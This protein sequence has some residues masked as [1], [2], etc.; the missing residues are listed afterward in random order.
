V[1]GLDTNAIL[2]LALDDDPAQCRRV[3]ALLG[4]ASEEMF[5]ISTI[6]LVEATWTLHRQ[7]KRTR[8]EIVAFLEQLLETED[9]VV[10]FEGAAWRALKDYAAGRSDYADYLIAEINLDMGCWTTF[11]FDED[12]LDA[13]AFSAIP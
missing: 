9:F 13:R 12:A 2:R 6:V 8:A 11:T 5:S 10:Q 4:N 3:V 7:L 1:I